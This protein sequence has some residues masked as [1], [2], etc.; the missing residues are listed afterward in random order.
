MATKTTFD[1]VDALITV[2]LADAAL[3][4]DIT[5]HIYRDGMRPV[6]SDKE[7][8]VVGTLPIT[9]EQIQR[10]I[11]NIN[12]HVPT[13]KITI[14]GIGNFVPNFVRLKEITARI[15]S[16]VNEKYIGDYWFLVQQQ[17]FYQENENETYSNIRVEFYSENIN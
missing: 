3:K 4:A 5:G 14:N 7:D 13:A 12:V 11:A 16:L 2:L 17:S 6:N 9:F 15:V 8:V 10:S 1:V